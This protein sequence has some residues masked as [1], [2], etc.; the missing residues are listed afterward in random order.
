MARSAKI[1]RQRKDSCPQ[2]GGPK[3]LASARCLAC[4]RGQPLALARYRG[5]TKT[6]CPSP[7]W[8]LATRDFL[9]QFAGIFMSE[10]CLHAA[11][12]RDTTLAIRLAIK[13]RADDHRC[14]ELIHSILGGGLRREKRRKNSKN[15]VIWEVTKR[16][17][18]RSILMAI[19]PLIVIP[20]KKAREIEAVLEYFAWRESVA[21]H[22]VDRE[23]TAAFARR[24][25]HLKRFQVDL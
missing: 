14:L 3:L 6:D 9:L 10:G 8:S 22:H 1:T 2:C 21:F 18:I 16:D 19:Q 20:M 7:D 15:I 13:L 5:R 25:S 23:R 4:K 17:D 12:S 11:L 24:I